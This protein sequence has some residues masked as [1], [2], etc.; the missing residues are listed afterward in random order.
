MQRGRGGG[1]E[2]LQ[3]TTPL[4]THHN[5]NKGKNKYLCGLKVPANKSCRGK[6]V[7]DTCFYLS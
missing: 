4:S 6:F 1:L 7:K 3:Y 2:Y 5:V